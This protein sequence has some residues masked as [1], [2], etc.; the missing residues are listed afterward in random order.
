MQYTRLVQPLVFLSNAYDTRL[1]HTTRIWLLGPSVV[2]DDQHSLRG[3]TVHER[4][5][6]GHFQ[7]Y[8]WLRSSRFYYGH[9]W[10]RL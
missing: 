7:L 8:Y 4:R 6:Y 1:D 3:N 2:C 9:E 5:A 10:K